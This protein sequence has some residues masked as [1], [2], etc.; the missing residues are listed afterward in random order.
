[1]S[2]P[3]SNT[4][5]TYEKPKSEKPRTAFTFGAPSM[6]VTMGYVT[7]SS[8]MSGLRSQREYTITCVSLRSGIASSGTVRIDQMPA[9]TATA[10]RR[11]T[12]NR[13]RAENSM[14]ALITAVSFMRRLGGGFRGLRRTCR[15]PHAGR[16]SF[17]LTLRVNQERPRRYDALAGGQTSNHGHAI[18]K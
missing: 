13:L 18:A 8:R 9:T 14:I 10:T 1:M 16:R 15:S 12:T 11:N 5:Y 7:W 2:V 3:S 17:E 6:A 4:M